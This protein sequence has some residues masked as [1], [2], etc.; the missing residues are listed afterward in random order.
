MGHKNGSS[1]VKDKYRNQYQDA[2]AYFMDYRF[3]KADESAKGKVIIVYK[4]KYSIKM[5]TFYHTWLKI[6][7]Y[8]AATPFTP[9]H[10]GS[11]YFLVW[12]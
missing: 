7:G 3:R 1:W 11:P 8:F 6:D 10:M 2:M 5:E 12:W 9:F 4:L